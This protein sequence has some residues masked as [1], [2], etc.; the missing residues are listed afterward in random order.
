MN[1][2]AK[3][4]EH[5]DGKLKVLRLQELM[6]KVLSQVEGVSINLS[7]REGIRKTARFIF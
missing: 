5:N 1:E 6:G 7:E 4:Q 3:K 2:I